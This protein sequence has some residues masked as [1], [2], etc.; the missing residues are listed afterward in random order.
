MYVGLT[1][2]PDLL[3][4]VFT[5][6]HCKAHD[7]ECTHLVLLRRLVL[8]LRRCL[9]LLRVVL[10]LLPSAA[11]CLAARLMVRLLV[12][13]RRGLVAAVDALLGSIPLLGCG[14][15]SGGATAAAA[16][17][18]A[19]QLREHRPDLVAVLG[20]DAVRLDL[21]LVVVEPHDVLL[22]APQEAHGVPAIHFHRV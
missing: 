21:E 8:L 11:P 1:G 13:R 17:A 12:L 22:L 3:Q 4:Q 5:E 15:V 14:R 19:E 7:R 10:L 18:L 9:V 20:A 16:A 6:T 2:R